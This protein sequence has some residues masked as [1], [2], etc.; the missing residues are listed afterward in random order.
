MMLAEQ[1]CYLKTLAYL[2]APELDA[3]DLYIVDAERLPMLRRVNGAVAYAVPSGVEPIEAALQDAGLFEGRGPAVIFQ[4]DMSHEDALVT[5]CHELGHL[6]PA[7]GDDALPVDVELQREQFSTFAESRD[8]DVEPGKPA[9][10]PAHGK[11][12]IRVALHCWWRLA[13]RANHVTDL[14]RLCGGW[15]YSLSPAYAYWQALGNEALLMQDATFREIVDSDLP[16]AFEALWRADL[17][18]W[19]KRNPQ[20]RE[21]PP[22]LSTVA[23]TDGAAGF[24]TD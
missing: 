19:S 2:I 16:P 15:E 6:L 18:E 24:P 1:L 4:R 10:Y 3:A 5:L 14:E 11:Q 23:V 7:P 17:R 12:F 20:N 22:R 21:A 8:G 13:L 9:W